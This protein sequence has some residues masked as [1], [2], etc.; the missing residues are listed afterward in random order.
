[1]SKTAIITGAGTG[2]G[3]G[4]ALAY[5]KAGYNLALAGRRVEPLEEIAGQCAGVRVEI[6]AADVA[7]P[8]AV[9]SLA[10]Q[11]TDAF[12]RIDILVNNAGINTKKRHLSDISDRDWGAR[13]RDQSLGRVLRFSRCVAADENATRRL[14]HQHFIYGRQAGG[15]D[16]RR[17]V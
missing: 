9:Q 7:D 15:D 16:Q 14:G 13:P 1:M 11:T 10:K 5:A 3:A 8:Q 2:I 17:G 12:G 4:I 6:R